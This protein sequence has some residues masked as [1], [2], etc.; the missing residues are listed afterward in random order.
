M[1]KIK[2]MKTLTSVAILAFASNSAWAAGT[3]ADTSI[4]NR[5]T[6]SYKVSGADQPDINSSPTGN[7]D[8]SACTAALPVDGSTPPAAATCATTFEVD[9]KIDLTVTGVATNVTVGPG[10]AS[11]AGTSITYTV[12][13]TGNSDEYFS[14]TPTQV[15]TSSPDDVFD[16]SAC[17]VTAP[18]LASG[19]NYPI[20]ADETINVTV[21]C[22]IPAASATVVSGAQSEVELLAT[23]ISTGATGTTAYVDSG[24]TETAAG[25]D[26]VLADGTGGAADSGARNASHSDTSGY[27]IS[28]AALNVTKTSAVVYDPINGTTNPKRIPGAVIRYDITVANTGPAD[29]T[30][31]VITDTIDGAVLYET[32][33]APAAACSS[34]AGVSFN[35]SESTT[36]TVTSDPFT[37]P[38]TTGTATMT[39]FV[40]IQ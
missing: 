32:A 37:V 3:A 26:I 27:V 35:C 19:T 18:V 39:F 6:I 34:T 14:L 7:S 38:A 31:V 30:D 23:A 25:V 28:T 10:Q 8:P 13:N 33:Q 11:G 24:T 5:A 12:A 36:G 21:Q 29:A 40:E 17:T 2:I 22:A 20:D 4:N 16:T 9:K 15:A 1:N